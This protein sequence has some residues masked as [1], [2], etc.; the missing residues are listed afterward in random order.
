MKNIYYLDGNIISEED[1]K[2]RQSSLVEEKEL[3]K[4]ILT[5]RMETE[6][7]TMFHFSTK[8]ILYS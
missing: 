6:D 1:L 7:S 3:K 5:S 2:Y 8:Q 4:I